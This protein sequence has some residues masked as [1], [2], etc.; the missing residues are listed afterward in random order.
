MLNSPQPVDKDTNYVAL[1]V[2]GIYQMFFATATI[3]FICH[4]ITY[5]HDNTSPNHSPAYIAISLAAKELGKQAGIYC[6]GIP[7][8]FS[9]DS[10]FL[11]AGTIFYYVY[12]W[13]FMSLIPFV[14]Q[15]GC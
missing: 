15:F 9:N 5:L 13:K 2:L 10:I 3:S 7:Y 14:F 11:S 8:F 1:V 12:D 6:T 4:G